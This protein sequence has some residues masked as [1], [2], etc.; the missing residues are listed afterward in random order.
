MKVSQLN[1]PLLPSMN[2]VAGYAPARRLAWMLV[3]VFLLLAI[4]LAFTPWQQSITGTGRSIALA[5]LERQ[6]TISAPVDGRDRKSVV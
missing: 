3:G 6:Q 5:P 1:Y 4:A 2:A